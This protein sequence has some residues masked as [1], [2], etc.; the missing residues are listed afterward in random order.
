[1]TL[2]LVSYSFVERGG[3]APV[4]QVREPVDEEVAKYL[5]AHVVDLVKRPTRKT[6]PPANFNSDE[7]R[8]RFQ[9]L[10]TGS[11]AAFVNSAQAL[12]NRL[13]VEMASV[14]AKKGF[15]VALRRIDGDASEGVVLKL[16]VSDEPAAALR[17]SEGVADL[18]AI[19]DLLD[20]PGALQKGAVSPDVRDGSDVIIGERWD[21]TTQYFLSALDVVQS[22]SERASVSQVLKVVQT[23]APER[24]PAVLE[25]IAR[26][27]A[28]TT[29]STLLSE[30]DLL[31]PQ[32]RREVLAELRQSPRPLLPVN[33]DHVPPIRRIQADG[34][35]ISG[36]VLEFDEKVT[37]RRQARGWRITVDVHEEPRDKL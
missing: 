8:Q 20:V 34:I 14:T 10:A 35:T 33:R 17:T 12:A 23:H 11:R 37:W 2:T 1:M 30:R 16:D 32:V 18:A 31:E 4:C 5:E 28:P 13:H 15:F 19:A 26:R 6:V 7:A 27:A 25:A 36:P 3:P 21:D 29:V 24:V 9:H 22:L